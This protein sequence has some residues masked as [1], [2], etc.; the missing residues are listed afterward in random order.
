MA[1]R[2]DPGGNAKGDPDDSELVGRLARGDEAAFRALYDRHADAV[3]NAA[4]R[5][6]GDAGGAADATQDVF[7]ALLEKHGTIADPS[8]VGAWL[9]RGAVHGAID[10]W[11]RRRLEPTSLDAAGA[12]AA[13]RTSPSDQPVFRLVAREEEDRVARAILALPLGL[14]EAIV[15]RYVEGASYEHIAAILGIEVGTVKSRLHRA[16]AALRDMLA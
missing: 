14:R 7:L 15:L 8:R 12:A 10:R 2:A 4:Y 9:V 11:R 6:L 5:M 3:F 1:S 13:G 16:H